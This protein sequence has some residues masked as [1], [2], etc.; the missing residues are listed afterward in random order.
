MKQCPKCSRVYADETLNFCLDDGEW[1][2]AD[3]DS[4]DAPTA[5]ISGSESNPG[6]PTQ[7]LPGIGESTVIHTPAG[8]PNGVIR[9]NKTPIFIAFGILILVGLVIGLVKFYR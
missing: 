5:I 4:A 8:D 7:T 2:L 6:Q 3:D 9:R 1:L